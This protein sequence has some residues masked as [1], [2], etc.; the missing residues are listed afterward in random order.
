MRREKHL[1][2]GNPSLTRH[3]CPNCGD[4]AIFKGGRCV[5]TGCGYVLPQYKN[6]HVWE[7]DIDRARRYR[8]E[9]M[10]ELRKETHRQIV[11]ARK[12]MR[13]L[14]EADCE[15]RRAR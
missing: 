7:S 1:H 5:R 10:R 15:R 2:F 13:Q 14:I 6:L 12:P 9:K 11:T 8:R 4:E 3:P